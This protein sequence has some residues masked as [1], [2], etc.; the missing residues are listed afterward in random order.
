ML[1]EV[2]KK[3]AEVCVLGEMFNCPYNPPLFKEYSEK[4]EDVEKKEFSSFESLL[5]TETPS[6]NFL[7]FASKKLDVM[8]IGGSIPL[9][10]TGNIYNTSLIFDKGE[11]IGYHDKV[12]LFDINIPNKISIKESDFVT[13]GEK[14]TVLQ[15]R[16]GNFGIGICYDIRFCNFAMAMRKLNAHILFYPS[17]FNLTTGP[18]HFQKTGIARALDTQC[19]VVL[20]SNARYV[21]NT[22]FMQCWGQ[23]S[24]I[25][26][27]GGILQDMHFEKGYLLQDIDLN[28]CLESR[29]NLPYTEYQM[30][31]DLYQLKII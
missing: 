20:A 23:S 4:W 1:K 18:L 9:S 30:R 12:H 8:L 15:T 3:G 6:V 28:S 14:I 21:E 7:K 25:D 5:K 27:N 31:E 24:I 13:R 29:L 17:V 2:K 26:Q 10:K 16:F 22:N 19:F 11:L